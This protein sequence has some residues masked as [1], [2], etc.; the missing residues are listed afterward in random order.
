MSL[1]HSS[2]RL[3]LC[4]S[5]PSL[6]L[7]E[8]H[9]ELAAVAAA[10]EDYDEKFMPTIDAKTSEGDEKAAYWKIVSNIV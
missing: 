9:N 5:L 7:F 3:S 4:L 1:S 2:S 6:I 8:R 10:A